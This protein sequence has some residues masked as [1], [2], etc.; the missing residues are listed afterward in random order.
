M[1]KHALLIGSIAFHATG[2]PGISGG[3][4]FVSD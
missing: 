4:F 1:K 2:I 3:G